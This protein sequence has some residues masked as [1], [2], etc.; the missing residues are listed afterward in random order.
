MFLNK[1]YPFLSRVL[2][3]VVLGSNIVSD[4]LFDIEMA[5][6][7]KKIHKDDLRTHIFVSGLPRSEIGRASCRERV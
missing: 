5:I 7:K 6:F 1:D 2:H 3:H 4:F